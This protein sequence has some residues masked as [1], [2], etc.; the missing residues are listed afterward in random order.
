MIYTCY[1]MIRDC[2]EDRPEGWSFLVTQYVPAIRRLLAHYGADDES[3]LNELLVSLRDPSSRLFQSLDPA[4]ERF[5]LV[6]LRQVALARIDPPRPAIE[7]DL[8]AVAAALEPLTML[9]KEVAW[10]ETM[11]YD[12]GRTAAMLRMSGTTVEAIRARAGELLRAGMDNWSSTVIAENGILLGRAAAAGGTPEC[13]PVR[14]LLDVIDGRATWRTREQ[15]ERHGS[16]CWHCIDHFCRIIEAVDLLRD[17]HPLSEAAA[18]PYRAVLGIEPPKSGLWK[19]L[20][21]RA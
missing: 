4:P 1:E 12:A 19:R 18:A 8:P 6:E 3:H 21:G 9:E 10:I 5:F 17:H 7:L 13:V 2:R 20:T 15:V 14:S 11:R 16:A